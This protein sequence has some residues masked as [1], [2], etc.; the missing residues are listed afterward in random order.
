[1]NVGKVL[2]VLVREKG[3]GPM[4]KEPIECV[5]FIHA[6]GTNLVK[7]G[8]TA[9]LQRR[10]DQLQTASPHRLRLLAVHIGPREVEKAYHRDLAPYRQRGEWFFLTHEVRRWLVRCLNSHYESNSVCFYFHYER[11]RSEEDAR[12]HE[13]WATETE[14]F[15]GIPGSQPSLIDQF[16]AKEVIEG[17]EGLIEESKDTEVAE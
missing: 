6:D 9:D 13:E 2:A 11:I 16:Q 3:L 7:I 1:M 4:S 14:S 5:Y 17:F 10:F 12:E 15:N 8:W